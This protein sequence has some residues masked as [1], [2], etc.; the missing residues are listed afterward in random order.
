MS[1]AEHAWLIHIVNFAAVIQLVECHLAKVDVKGSNP[2]RRLDFFELMERKRHK[3]KKNLIPSPPM[4]KY[5]GE[6]LG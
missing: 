1:E 4:N 2:F 6:G 3:F 5:W